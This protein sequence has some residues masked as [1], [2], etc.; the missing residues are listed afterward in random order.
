[1]ITIEGRSMT[2]EQ[3]RHRLLKLLREARHAG[4][5]PAC[6][7]LELATAAAAIVELAHVTP[8]QLGRY[9]DGDDSAAIPP[10]HVH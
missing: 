4:C 3:F 5:C 1:M 8:D 2:H 7:T 9:L 10:T 6:I